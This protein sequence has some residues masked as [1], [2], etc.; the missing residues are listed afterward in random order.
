M[1]P[2]KKYD[3]YIFDCDGTLAD[4][5]P[6]HYEAWKYG[7]SEC[8][9]LFEFSYE[10][11]CSWGGKS[12]K[13]TVDDLNEMFGTS[14]DHVLVGQVVRH[15]IKDHL[16]NVKPR[17]EITAIAHEVACYAKVSVASG[18]S[19][20]NVATTLKAIG[21]DE[22]FDIVVTADDVERSKPAPDLFLLAADK[23]ELRPENCLVFEDSKTGEAA[24]EAAGMDC[25]FVG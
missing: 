18:G 5:M 14:L 13:G 6:L 23:M 15:Y 11:M 12:L 17:R 21:V 3:G 25:V 4:S 2:E 9:A 24:A 22:L 8:G 7:L 20:R 10:L 1:L 16:A 19:R